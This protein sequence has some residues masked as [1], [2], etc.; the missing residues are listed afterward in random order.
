MTNSDTVD[1]EMARRTL[2]YPAVPIRSVKAMWNVQDMVD[3]A[4]LLQLLDQHRIP[5]FAAKRVHDPA[6]LFSNAFHAKYGKSS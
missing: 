3:V 4:V 1:P 5:Y 6:G 2:H